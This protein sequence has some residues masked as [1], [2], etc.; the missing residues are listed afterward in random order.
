MVLR[1]S[2]PIGNGREHAWLTVQAYAWGDILVVKTHPVSYRL[3][4]KFQFIFSLDCM[5]S[6]LYRNLYAEI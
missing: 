5:K 1:A 3:I 4:D 2:K 6:T